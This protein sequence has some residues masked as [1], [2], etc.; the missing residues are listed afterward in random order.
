MYRFQ[1]LA[2]SAKLS[3]IDLKK[4]AEEGRNWFREK[5]LG[6]K[7]ANPK[8]FQKNATAFQNQMSISPNAIGK[9]YFYSYDPFYAKELDYYDV[10]PMVFPIEF[11]TGA[12]NP[13]FLGINLHYLPPFTRARL[14]DAL[15]STMNNQKYDKTTK[16]QISYGI[17]KGAAQFAPFK[18]CVHRYRFDRVRSPFQY[19]SPEAWDYAILLPLARF[20]KASQDRVWAE[21]LM[22]I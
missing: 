9:L 5:A 13:G 10:F 2:K 15:Y 3:G 1:Q 6:T 18:P 4:D 17:L 16:L 12:T 11:Y 19:V 21:S 14:M 22:K 8:T 7:Y 20:K